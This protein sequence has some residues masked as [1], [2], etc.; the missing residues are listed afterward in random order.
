YRTGPALWRMRRERETEFARHQEERRLDF[1][2]YR[3]LQTELREARA[4]SN[5]LE[6][7]LELTGALDRDRIGDALLLGFYFD[8]RRDGLPSSPKQSI[9]KTAAVR[10]KVLS[11]SA[12]DVRLEKPALH[13]VLEIV[14]GPVVA[15]SF[16]LGYVLSHLGADGLPRESSIEILGE[17]EKQLGALKLDTKPW[18][19]NGTAGISSNIRNLAS[20]VVSIIRH[21]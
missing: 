8:R 10:L 17:I 2:Q 20:R 1:E 3:A 13:S 16:D 21:F 6:K 11:S 18:R 5:S 9:F 4:H 19:A 7:K 14:Y 15:E 12:A